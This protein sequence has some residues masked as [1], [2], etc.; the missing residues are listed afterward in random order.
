MAKNKTS[1]KGMRT[2]PIH[3]RR[4]RIGEMIKNIKTGE[5]ATVASVSEYGIHITPMPPSVWV[6]VEQFDEWVIF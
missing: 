1:S 4:P 6:T 2:Q 3:K 5:R